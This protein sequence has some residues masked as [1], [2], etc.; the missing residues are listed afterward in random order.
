MLYSRGQVS[1][2]LACAALER[3]LIWAV[4][5]SACRICKLE[6]AGRVSC[7][8]LQKRTFCESCFIPGGF[9]VS[10]PEANVTFGCTA[11]TMQA[12]ALKPN[13]L[14]P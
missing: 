4:C 10:F 5:A 7:N 12:V 14:L 1:G 3:C 11:P 2:R 6:S 8:V 9:S 13:F